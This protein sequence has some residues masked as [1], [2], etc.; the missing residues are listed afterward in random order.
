MG[1]NNIGLDE[2]RIPSTEGLLSSGYVAAFRTPTFEHAASPPGAPYSWLLHDH[3]EDSTCRTVTYRERERVAASHTGYTHA[4]RTV[5]TQQ[6]W[7]GSV[8]SDKEEA[9]S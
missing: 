2:Q 3:S 4:Q 5:C 9:R 8:V 6:H 7:V 1:G